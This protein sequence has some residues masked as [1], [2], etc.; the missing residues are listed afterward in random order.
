MVEPLITAVSPCSIS[1]SRLF[2][3]RRYNSLKLPSFHCLLLSE[4]DRPRRVVKMSPPIEVRLN[5]RRFQVYGLSI[6]SEFDLLLPEDSETAAPAI[7]ITRAHPDFFN[8]FSA[9]AVPPHH[10]K[11]YRYETFP[12]GSS[13][14][15]W[16]DLFDFFIG[17]DGRTMIC[18]P[19][20]SFSEAYISY[21][22]SFALSFALLRMGD[23]ALHATVIASKGQAIGLLGES[24]AGKSTLASYF[25]E[26]GSR[27]VTDDLL[28]VTFRDQSVIAHPGPQR[29]K[30]LPES[31]AQFMQGA[32]IAMI[33]FTMK[34]LIV[35]PADQRIDASVP[36]RALY[37]LDCF[38]NVDESNSVRA[39]RLRSAEATLTVIASTFNN[40]VKT[41][42]RLTRQLRFAGQL[43]SR[44]PVFRLSYPRRFDVLSSVYELIA[45][46]GNARDVVGV[47]RGPI[48]GNADTSFPAARSIG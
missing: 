12:D 14:L 31:A 40:I 32:T 4:A 37:L 10:R 29:I 45:H 39:E 15:S 41:P 8:A 35:P 13:Y 18:G 17:S 30:L 38:E 42:E 5:M 43:L 33:P 27:L 34:Q 46:E 44:I 47:R 28:R 26:N 19:R 24:G 9:K 11:S 6:A 25:L 48:F 20:D 23:E 16:N 2:I 21:L 22:V 3:I 7:T 36:L 1:I